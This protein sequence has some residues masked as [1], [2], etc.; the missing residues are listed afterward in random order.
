MHFERK[1]LVLYACIRIFRPHMG[2]GI[3]LTQRPPLCCVFWIC[4]C[5]VECFLEHNIAKR[6]YYF[7][8]IYKD[9]HLNNF[10]LV[11]P[12]NMYRHRVLH[13]HIES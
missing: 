3:E 1:H 11:C 7:F 9:C 6:H 8:N 10:K 4:F 2:K 12:D 5:A 13:T